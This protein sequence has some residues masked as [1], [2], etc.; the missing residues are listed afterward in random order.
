MSP[1]GPPCNCVLCHDYGD[2]HRMD[3]FLLRTIV[4]ISEYGWSVVLVQPGRDRPGWAYTI[5]LWHSH[6]TPE[7]AMFGA[8]VYET[9]EILNTLGRAS[10]AGAGPL[11]GERRPDTV[12]GHDAVFRSVDARWYHPLFPGA[13]SFHRRPPLPFL[14][15]VWPDESNAFPWDPDA[16]RDTQPWT[17]LPPAH[18]PPSPWLP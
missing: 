4:H 18:H 17:W 5:G 6:R 11:D 12:R 16:E 7:L 8:D 14:Q 9:E 2:R 13:V 1:G 10:A 3:T 15:L